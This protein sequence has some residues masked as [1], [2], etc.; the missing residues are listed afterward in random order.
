MSSSFLP[1]QTFWGKLCLILLGNNMSIF[2]RYDNVEVAVQAKRIGLRHFVSQSKPPQRKHK[3]VC[4]PVAAN[5]IRS[6][7][8]SSIRKF[9]DS[10]LIVWRLR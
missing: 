3:V 7:S 6:V 2:G 1:R 9:S 4:L 5:R 8:C 10:S